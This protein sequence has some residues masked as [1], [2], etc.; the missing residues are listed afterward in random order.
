MTDHD[1][2]KLLSYSWLIQVIHIALPRLRILPLV[3]QGEPRHCPP[4]ELG[5]ASG[6]LQPE[7][8]GDFAEVYL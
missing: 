4:L 3:K 5:A 6:H 8:A 7:H 2:Q 1:L